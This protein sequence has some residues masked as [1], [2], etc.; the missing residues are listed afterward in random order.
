MKINSNIKKKPNKILYHH[1]DLCQY[2]S[3]FVFW[4][5]LLEDFT[6]QR[7]LSHAVST[8]VSTVYIYLKLPYSNFSFLQTETIGLPNIMHVRRERK[9]MG[10]H[11]SNYFHSKG[12]KLYATSLSQDNF[13]YHK[14]VC[15][16]WRIP[17]SLREHPNISPDRDK[18]IVGNY[19]PNQSWTED[20]VFLALL[21]CFHLLQKS[22]T[23]G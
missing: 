16:L 15:N 14:N 8:T 10:V 1:L 23:L 22:D 9:G 20:L 11:L 4:Q 5:A 13:K 17:E 7:A 2:P 3:K 21:S 6:L 19:K 12:R 18:Q